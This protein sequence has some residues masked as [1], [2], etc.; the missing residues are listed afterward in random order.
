MET[1]SEVMHGQVKELLTGYG[2]IDYIWFDFSYPQRDWGIL[3]EKGKMTGVRKNW[4]K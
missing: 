2:K 1:L 3:L 4:K